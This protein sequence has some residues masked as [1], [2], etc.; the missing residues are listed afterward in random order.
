MSMAGSTIT[1]AS[2]FGSPEDSHSRG[3]SSVCTAEVQLEMAIAEAIA[4]VVILF[5][6]SFDCLDCSVFV[7]FE[8]AYL[9]ASEPCPS[10]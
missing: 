4:M 9:E 2:T 6:K 8:L 10:A 5:I 3:F 7:V 1:S